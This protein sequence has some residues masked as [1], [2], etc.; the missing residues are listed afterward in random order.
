MFRYVS[1]FLMSSFV[2]CTTL[3]VKAQHEEPKPVET[4]SAAPTTH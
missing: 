1:I 2:L 4:G 3:L